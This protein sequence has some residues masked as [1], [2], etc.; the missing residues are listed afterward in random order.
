M[1][2]YRLVTYLRTDPDEER[3]L[4]P[5]EARREVAQQRLLFPEHIHQLEI[6]DLPPEPSQRRESP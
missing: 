2:K 4:E 5:E 3:L 1:K 6:A